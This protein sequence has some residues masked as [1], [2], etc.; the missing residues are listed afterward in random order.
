MN[1]TNLT[2]VLHICLWKSEGMSELE[3]RKHLANLVNNQTI[4]AGIK[5]YEYLN[6]IQIN[7]Q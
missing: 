5:M 6:S 1:K 4:N 7:Q 3:I 2:A